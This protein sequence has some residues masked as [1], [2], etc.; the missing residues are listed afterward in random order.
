MLSHP[1]VGHPT[2]RADWT[3]TLRLILA[4]QRPVLMTFFNK[5]DRDRDLKRVDQEATSI[6]LKVNYLMSADYP[7]AFHSY[8]RTVDNRTPLEGIFPNYYACVLLPQ[9]SE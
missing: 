3:P 8:K 9:A 7:N 4:A 1:G 6:Q 5:E 2:L